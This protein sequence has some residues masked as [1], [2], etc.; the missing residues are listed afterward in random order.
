MLLYFDLIFVNIAA[1][2]ARHN[3]VAGYVALAGRLLTNIILIP[4]IGYLGAAWAALAANVS[5][6]ILATLKVCRTFPKA[7][8]LQAA[9]GAAAAA[10]VMMAVFWAVPGP[11]LPR[12]LFGLLSYVIALC[13]AGSITGEHL[14]LAL[15]LVRIRPAAVGN[16]QP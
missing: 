11:V 16:A 14:R 3:F 4:R 13:L 1:G 12:T 5:F 2:E 6:A 10:G 9:L 7:R 15:Q 8:I